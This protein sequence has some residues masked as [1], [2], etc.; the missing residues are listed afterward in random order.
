MPVFHTH[1]FENTIEEELGQTIKNDCIDNPNG[2]ITD[3]CGQSFENGNQEFD[4]IGKRKNTKN[5]IKVSR[6][7]IYNIKKSTFI[8][9]TLNVWILI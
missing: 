1:A 2:I 7:C 4:L 3:I 8:A 6:P 9:S 5:P